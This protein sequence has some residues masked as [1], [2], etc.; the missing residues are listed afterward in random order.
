MPEG[1]GADWGDEGSSRVAE[2]GNGVR[3]AAPR[4]EAGEGVEVAGERV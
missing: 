2:D 4:A 1:G 3:L